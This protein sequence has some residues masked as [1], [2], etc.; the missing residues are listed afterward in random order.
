MPNYQ[1]IENTQ[2]DIYVSISMDHGCPFEYFK[3]MDFSVRILLEIA[4]KLQPGLGKV[5][6]GWV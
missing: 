5:S 4:W 6:L 2:M 3:L 1:F